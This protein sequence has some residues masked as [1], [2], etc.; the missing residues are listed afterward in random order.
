MISDKY[1]LA[2]SEA[3]A[4]VWPAELV[5]SV[6]QQ[7]VHMA[8][9]MPC[10]A[11]AT[12]QF[13]A[14]NN[15]NIYG[16]CPL[17]LAHS[18]AEDLIPYRMLRD[19]V[20]SYLESVQRKQKEQL[21][22]PTVPPLPPSPAGPSESIPAITQSPSPVWISP[23]DDTL[24]LFKAAMREID[25]KKHSSQISG[26][27]GSSAGMSNVFFKEKDLEDISSDDL[28]FEDSEKDPT[29]KIY[30]GP[31]RS[32][33]SQFWSKEQ[34]SLPEPANNQE[35]PKKMDDEQGKVKNALRHALSNMEE[36]D[37]ERIR[38]MRKLLESS[39]SSKKSKRK[40]EKKKKHKHKELKIKEK[41]LKRLLKKEFKEE[42]LEK[43]LKK[44][45]KKD[46]KKKRLDCS[47]EVEDATSI[48]DEESQKTKSK[49]TFQHIQVSR[50][51][52]W[53]LFHFS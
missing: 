42:V 45:K 1:Y 13:C 8:V 16:S 26:S 2:M 53:K 34:E 25:A 46:K 44:K 4:G 47:R 18:K 51:M 50:T 7:L 35:S 28:D 20:T 15:I 9:M 36:Y 10:C 38:K 19:R 41:T 12:C 17:C 6:C 29:E 30:A 48:S 21:S 33:D 49:D 52:E 22:L 5:C 27:P 43:L 37:Q 31:E 32:C 24:L 39:Q 14:K 3:G 23:E 40:K 11:G